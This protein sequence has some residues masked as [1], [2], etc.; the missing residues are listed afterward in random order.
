MRHQVAGMLRKNR[1][2]KYSKEKD[3]EEKLRVRRIKYE[4][5]KAKGA[6]VTQ[7]GVRLR[8]HILG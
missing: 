5:G 7:S 2:C 4:E 6:R 3:D 8:K 1:Q